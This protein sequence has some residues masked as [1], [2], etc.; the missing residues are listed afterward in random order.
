MPTPLLK[1]PSYESYFHEIQPIEHSD[2]IISDLYQTS[3][4]SFVFSENQP[5]LTIRQTSHSLSKL[6][7]S[8]W[9]SSL[10]LAS[11]LITHPELISNKNVLELGSGLALPSIL[12]SRL[13]AKSVTATDYWT[14]EETDRLIP[15]EMYKDAIEYNIRINEI[16]N[17]KVEKLGEN[18]FF[19]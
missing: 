9:S 8:I 6:G 10:A 14:D 11:Y 2:D 15:K 5:P 12:S 7:S 16:Q 4:R 3:F 1:T 13:N 18:H 17:C 19:N